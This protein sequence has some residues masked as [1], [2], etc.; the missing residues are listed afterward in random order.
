[1]QKN[2]KIAAA[3]EPQTP[4][5]AQKDDLRQKDVDQLLTFDQSKPA[6]ASEKAETLI[7][8]ESTVLLQEANREI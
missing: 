5:S 4:G 7:E 8:T 1:M 3:V 6:E 2:E